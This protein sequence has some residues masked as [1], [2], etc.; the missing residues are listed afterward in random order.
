MYF[1]QDF[2]RRR[3]SRS[4]IVVLCAGFQTL[5]VLQE[6]YCCTLCRISDADG[7][8]G[9]VLLYCVQDFRRRRFSRA[10]LL[11]FVQDFRRRRCSR[12]SIVVLCAGFQALT[13]LQEQ[14]CCTLCRISSADGASGAVLLYYGVSD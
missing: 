11:Y 7:A 13:V 12:S 6:Q 1:V 2:E 10:V 9:A 14:Y 3:C 5:T 4:S 8:P